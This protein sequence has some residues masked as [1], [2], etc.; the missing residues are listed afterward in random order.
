VKHKFQSAKSDGADAT[1]VQ[2]SN[3][4]DV[5]VLNARSVSATGNIAAT[6]DLILATGGSGGITLTLPSPSTNSGATFAFFRVDAAAGAVTITGTGL[7][8]AMPNQG[9]LIEVFSDGT[10]W[11]LR[12][13][14]D[15]GGR[16]VSTLDF[17][18]FP[19]T[20]NTSLNITGQGEIIAASVVTAWIMPAATADH[21]AEEH[22]IEQF[23]VFAGNIVPGTGF[24]IYGQN[25]N[26]PTQYDQPLIYGQWTVGWSWS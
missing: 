13:R 3:W 19:G 4:N 18:A 2:A 14:F 15:V 12:K 20:S 7:T 8:V 23:E 16:G 9:D 22:T 10:N 1:Q 24:T 17:G 6:D 11:Q 25:Y 5:H 21:S 26:P